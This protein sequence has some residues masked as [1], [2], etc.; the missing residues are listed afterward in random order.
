MEN[1]ALNTTAWARS[2]KAKGCS[3]LCQINHEY[4]QLKRYKHKK[5]NTIL[6]NTSKISYKIV[7]F[8]MIFVHKFFFIKLFDSWHLFH[9]NHVLWI[10]EYKC[11]LF[12][13]FCQNEA[14]AKISVFIKF[15]SGSLL[16]FSFIYEEPMHTLLMNQIREN[17]SRHSLI[18]TG[19][20]WLSPVRMSV[21]EQVYIL[22]PDQM[23]WM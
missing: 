23:T 21:S 3:L 18:S 11:T 8:Y 2:F 5:W 13:F 12:F 16:L 7:S 15:C 10:Y 4:L 1:D 9:L 22:A 20:P 14:L 17:H 19:K 6:F